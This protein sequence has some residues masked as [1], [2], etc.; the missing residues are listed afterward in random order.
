MMSYQVQSVVGHYGLHELE[1]GVSDLILIESDWPPAFSL[2]AIFVL[3]VG[4]HIE[5]LVDHV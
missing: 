2:V 4:H 1:E 3:L 5:S